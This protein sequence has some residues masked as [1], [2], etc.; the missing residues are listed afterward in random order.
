MILQGHILS[1]IGDA[2]RG[3]K[4]RQKNAI[5][6]P[7]CVRK[8]VGPEGLMVFARMMTRTIAVLTSMRTITRKENSDHQIQ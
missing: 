8:R 5:R 2:L 3:L 1:T 4:K 7:L 6:K